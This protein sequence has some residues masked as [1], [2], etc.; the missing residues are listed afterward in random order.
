[1]NDIEI[2]IFRSVIVYL[3]IIVALRLFGKKEL[4]QLSIIDLVFILLIS[5]SVQ[6]AMVGDNTS[7]LGGLTAATSLFVINWLLKNLIFRSKNLSAMVQGNPIMLVYHGKIIHKHLEQARLSM[8]ELEAAIREH[9]VEDIKDVD[10]V[11]LE[12]DGNISVLSNDF[13]RKTVKKR[14]LHKSLNFTN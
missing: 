2:V 4:T 8:D 11:I 12:V 13:K 14:R 10:I 1:M 3:F 7:L 6:N 5:N 9:G